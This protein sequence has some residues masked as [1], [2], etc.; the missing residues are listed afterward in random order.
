M[1]N[2]IKTEMKN[3]IY[4]TLVAGLILVGCSPYRTSFT[5]FS[6]S[7]QI[8]ADFFK[9]LPQP[10]DGKIDAYKCQFDEVLVEDDNLIEVT[11]RNE[12]SKQ[13][14]ITYQPELRYWRELYLF[15]YKDKDGKIYV[16][17]FTAKFKYDIDPTVNPPAAR[18]VCLGFGP[19]YLG[20]EV[21]RGPNHVIDFTTNLKLD[22][23]NNKYFLFKK[24][25]GEMDHLNFVIRNDDFTE[26]SFLVSR[27]IN[28]IPNKIGGTKSLVYNVDS[29]FHD[30]RALEFH[31][32]K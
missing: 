11:V 10:V 13:D 7:E 21:L 23:K 5:S 24:T 3:R 1:F 15:K 17:Y 26:E 19:S 14:Q 27:I 31:H 9:E 32:Q 25:K 12:N 6:I 30:K 22:R 28:R 16:V 4:I 29:V 2:L 20:T 18:Q 8:N